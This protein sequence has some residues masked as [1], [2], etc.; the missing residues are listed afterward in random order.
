MRIGL[1]RQSG[2]ARPTAAP[3]HP[4][5]G[6]SRRWPPRA[7]LALYA[8][9][10]LF[11]AAQNVAQTSLAPV[12]ER[13]LHLRPST[14]GATIALSGVA[15]LAATMLVGR[16]ARPATLRR[17][18]GAG[19]LVTTAS[20]PVIAAA[21]STLALVAGASL[22]GGGG[23]LLMP[24]LTTLVGH[25]SGA[26]AR[27]R[28]A[29]LTVAL[30][31]S[32]SIG[33]LVDSGLLSASG[34]SLRLTLVVFSILPL[35]AMTLLTRWT[36]SGKRSL[37]LP[38]SGDSG[39]QR[40]ATEPPPS[41]ARLDAG[42]VE[43][44]VP[45]GAAVLPSSPWRRPGWRLATAAQLLYQAPFVA[46]VSFGVV[47]AG[48]LD[49]MPPAGAQLAISVFF[50]LSLLARVALT[51]V[52]QIRRPKAAILLVAVLTGAGVSLL[53]LG[54]TD[55][56]LFV[57]LAMLG[58]PHG[59]VYPLA[60]GLVAEETPPELLSRA[61]AA[62]AAW[63]AAVTIPLPAVLGAIA[64]TAGFRAMFLLLLVPI[65]GVGALVVRWPAPA[66]SP[67]ARRG[68]RAG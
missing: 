39:E 19:L 61:N 63:T 65:V 36:S 46:V 30:S 37:P 59:L 52:R 41:D 5:S 53:G 35:L 24:S 44:P 10:L 40:A 33:P 21:R 6:R 57:A 17:W 12:G 3:R 55:A 34:N 14:V 23:G 64:A 2:A 1:A 38:L 60:L 13:Y 16:L 9:A 45:L 58:L 51:S 62:L 27:R 50:V 25:Q 47:A 15:T 7:L 18:L 42:G 54:H 43:P 66:M 8:I 68:E 4:G 31:V 22:L 67:R 26:S 28:L 49:R 20:F 48:R 56:E 11:R 29:G 32:L